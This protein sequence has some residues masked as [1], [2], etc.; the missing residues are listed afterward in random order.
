M[1]LGCV[2]CLLNKVDIRR[3]VVG[4]RDVVFQRRVLMVSQNLFH[5]Y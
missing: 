4:L 5:G 1:D 3:G 2:S